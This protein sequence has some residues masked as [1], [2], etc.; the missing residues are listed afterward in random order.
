MNHPLT[1]AIVA[2]HRQTIVPH[3]VLHQMLLIQA[4]GDRLPYGSAFHRI[5][6]AAEADKG[7]AASCIIAHGELP[8]VPRDQGNAFGNRLRVDTLV[9]KIK[10]IL[11]QLR[12]H[13][14]IVR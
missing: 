13:I 2:I 10:C 3:I 7:Q 6:L 5:L 14:G 1:H 12:H 11:L 4:R 8:A 9:Q